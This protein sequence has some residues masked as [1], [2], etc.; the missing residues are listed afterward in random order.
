M[1]SSHVWPRWALAIELVLVGSAAVS[2]AWLGIRSIDDAWHLELTLPFS[3]LVRSLLVLVVAPL[4]AARVL[5]RAF[6]TIEDA[7]V[8]DD[9]ARVW[10]WPLGGVL[11]FTSG[12]IVHVREEHKTDIRRIARL[13]Y[14]HLLFPAA[15]AILLFDLQQDISW[16]G[17]LG[18]YRAQG[19]GPWLR[20]Y[21]EVA[22]ATIV[23]LAMYAVLLRFLIAFVVHLSVRDARRVQRIA[24]A[25]RFVLYDLA[26]PIAVASRINY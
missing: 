17:F 11:V 20:G 13:A 25:A 7:S 8:L 14:R 19:L 10:P 3:L 12:R 21:A 22:G 18:Q 4:V 15:V 1:A 23:Y 2:F 24:S 9:E 16:G 5:E 26:V 6:L